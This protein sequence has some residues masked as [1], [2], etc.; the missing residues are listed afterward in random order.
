[1]KI[2]LA[3]FPFWS[4]LTPPLGISC[5][6]SVLGKNGYNVKTV[7]TNTRSELWSFH[8]RYIAAYGAHINRTLF[9]QINSLFLSQDFTNRY[10]CFTLQ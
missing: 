1:M 2:L 8:S 7:D 6:K 4:P 10:N 3:L 9:T 5:L